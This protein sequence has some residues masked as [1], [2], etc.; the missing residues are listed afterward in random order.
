VS[1]SQASLVIYE[2][3]LKLAHGL[4]L[5][6]QGAQ[7]HLIGNTLMEVVSFLGIIKLWLLK[8]T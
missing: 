8:M 6:K 4:N 7:L 3:I 5:K 1:N 2:A